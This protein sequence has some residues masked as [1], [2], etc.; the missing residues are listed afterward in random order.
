MSD[1]RKVTERDFRME[2]FK[3]AKIEDYEFR[4]DGKLV[5]KDRWE[6]GIGNI[7]AIL[8]ISHYEISDVVE[9]VRDLA[10]AEKHWSDFVES[11]FSIEEN[12]QRYSLKTANGSVMKGAVARVEYADSSKKSI[13]VAFNWLGRDVYAHEVVQ[14]KEELEPVNA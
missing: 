4:K 1:G 11:D 10:S 13:Y 12:G 14:W 5:R 6:R 3:D 7:A 9:K 2:E 8:N